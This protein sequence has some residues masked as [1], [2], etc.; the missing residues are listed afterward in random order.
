MAKVDVRFAGSL[1]QSDPKSNA[2]AILGKLANLKTVPYD[3]VKCKLEPRVDKDTFENALALLKGSDSCP[4]W[5]NAATIATIPA[6]IA[7]HNTPSRAHS[8]SKLV[9]V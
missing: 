5:L 4:L 1:S 9:K 2:V 7:R 8:I 6:Q 3:V